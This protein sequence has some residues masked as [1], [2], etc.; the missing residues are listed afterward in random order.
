MQQP[1]RLFCLTLEY[2]NWI[3]GHYMYSWLAPF[4]TFAVVLALY[5]VSANG[6][7]R[8]AMLSDINFYIVCVLAVAIIAIVAGARYGSDW[9]DM[10]AWLAAGVASLAALWRWRKI[11]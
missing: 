11:A 7:K 6:A 1:R 10:G 8:E 3:T 4:V 5:A 2:Q 9:L